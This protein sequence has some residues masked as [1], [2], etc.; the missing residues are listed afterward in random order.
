MGGALAHLYYNDAFID[1]IDTWFG[2]HAVGKDLVVFSP[3]KAYPDE[4]Y[5]ADITGYV[6]FNGKRKTLLNTFLPYF[7]DY[8]SSPTVSGSTIYYWGLASGNEEDF[9]RFLAMRYDFSVADVESLYLETQ[10]L[11][12]DDQGY[13][14]PPEFN[15]EG[16]IY[17]RS[18][19]I[20]G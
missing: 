10:D 4:P 8:F 13:F 16:I 9:Y 14:N 19:A 18:D 17:Q 7:N 12:T 2:L 15:A 5:F 6:V 11:G 1:S 3:V 20:R